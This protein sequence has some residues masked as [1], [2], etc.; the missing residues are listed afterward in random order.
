MINA[1]H[2]LWIVPTSATFGAMMLA[3]VAAA[4]GGKRR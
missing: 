1:W 3:V 4:S 2:L